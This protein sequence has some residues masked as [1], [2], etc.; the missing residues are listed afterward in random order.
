MTEVK[1]TY[2]ESGVLKSE[3]FELNGKRNGEILSLS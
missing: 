1:R 3:C 2:Y